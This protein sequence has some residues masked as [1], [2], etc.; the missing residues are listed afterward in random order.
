MPSE[1]QQ[2]EASLVPPQNSRSDKEGALACL[3]ATLVFACLLAYWWCLDHS[4]PLWDAG[5]HFQDAIKYAQLLRH[6]HILQSSFWH[7]FLTVSFNYPL[8]Q[9]LIFGASK[10]LFG[11]GRFSDALVNVLYLLLLSG[12]MARLIRLSGG[13]WRA[14]SFA[15][16]LI[17]CYPTVA[18]YSHSQMLD[19]GHI[20][21]SSFGLC[22]MAQWWQKKSTA[23][24]IFM[25]IALSL[26]VTAKQA[27]MVFLLVPG[28][29]VLVRSAAQKDKKALCQLFAAALSAALSLLIW[30]IPNRES[31]SAWRDYY[32]PQATQHAGPFL[33][34]FEHLWL[35]LTSLP[36]LMSPLL[37]LLW[38]I[39][40]GSLPRAL[41]SLPRMLLLSAMVTGIPL[42]CLLSMNNAEARYI[43]PALLSPA[44]ETALLLAAWWQSGAYGKPLRLAALLTLVLALTQYLLLNFSPYPIKMPESLVNMAK[45]LTRCETDLVGPGFAP[46]PA[47]DPWGQ[48]WLIEH[49]R[50][51]E[52]GGKCTLNMLPSTK[53]LSVH[54]MTV[55][56]L[57]ANYPISISTFR[58][59]T[60]NGDVFTCTQGDIDYFDWYLVKDGF[61]GKNLADQESEK[62]YKALETLLATSP[63][64]KLI[65][66]KTL[67]DS[68][69]IKLYRRIKR[70]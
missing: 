59:F 3:G 31:L 15:V 43:M 32:T 1:S 2:V 14:A 22:A 21:L 61:N 69:T 5:S 11:Y 40:I 27:A 49:I 16:I 66:Q 46:V 9:H 7:E 30:L 41:P 53:E 29:L 67:P 25:C 35:Y 34:F 70:P 47:G 44:L 4:F 20:A 42:M 6:P 50:T 57:L 13:S 65:G 26:A 18:Q 52:K 23:N 62:A 36:S 38:L 17:N 37:F 33:V 68:S 51:Y 19:F 60:L 8:T 64:F 54:T 39:S 48:E 28:L 12:S 58:R 63:S 55:A 10:A 24:T 56:F 45:T